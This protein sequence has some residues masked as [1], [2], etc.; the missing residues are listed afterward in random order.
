MTFFWVQNFLTDA[1]TTSIF[2]HSK[3][4][5]IVLEL[6]QLDFLCKIYASH[7]LTYRVGH[8]GMSGFHVD[9]ITHAYAAIHNLTFKKTLEVPKW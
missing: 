5:P 6:H 7:N 9:T 2:L 1:K 4:F 8:H 3:N